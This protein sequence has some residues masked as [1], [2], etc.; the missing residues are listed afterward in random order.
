MFKLKRPL[1]ISIKLWLAMTLVILTV[2]GGLGL[3][4]T[5]LF[6]DFY[7]QQKL[8]ALRTEAT[9]IATE[10]A[11]LPDWP[12][13]LAAA[14]T[15][16]L[17]SG[18]QLVILDAGGNTLAVMGASFGNG[19]RGGFGFG[20]MGGPMSGW[21]RSPRPTD[22]FTAQNL[23]QVLSGDTLSIKAL[24]TNGNGQAMLIAAAPI[25]PNAVSGVVL[26]GSS[27]VPIQES[28]N[29]FRRLI[30]YASLL[31][32]I[33]A[34]LVS[35]ILARQMT[36]P[37]GLMQRAAKRMAEGNFDPIVGV[38][39][40]DE[41][42]EL[43]STLNS[44]GESLL[45]HVTWLSEEKNLLEGIVEGISDAVI[46]LGPNG[47][48]LYANDPAQALWTEDER[49]SEERK[50][51]I[52]AFLKELVAEKR[53]GYPLI[54]EQKSGAGVN[55]AGPDGSEAE[56]EILTLG[57]Q[58]LQIGVASLAENGGVRGNVLVLR[59][60]T[61]SLRAEKERRDFL[62]SVTHELRTPLHLI[63]GYL[64]AIQDG[65]IPPQEEGEH[66]NLV[67]DESKRLARLVQSLQEI[68]R[69]E[70][71]QALQWSDISLS[72][73]M[74]DLNQRFQGKA[75]D[76]GVRLLIRPGTG[77][78][79]ADRDRLLQV[80]INLI[81]NAL[82]HTPSGRTVVVEAENRKS[83]ILFMV[84]DEGEGIPP[85]A[86]R[87][88][89]ERFYRVDKSRSR[90]EGGMGLGLAI[91]KQ[92]VETHNGV[93]KVESELGQGTTFWVEIPNR[94]SD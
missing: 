14:Q 12:Q 32:I 22:F 71:S 58:I 60:V 73:F 15:S 47:E 37:L 93:I 50:K 43:A 2:L 84:R 44:M 49:E 4:I 59:D 36:R 42:G 40:R 62:A 55:E 63:Q 66:I 17:T 61:A 10:L 76:L 88:I 75:S 27:T 68:N 35:L 48:L 45:N 28:I 85:E 77:Q 23:L 67:L 80:F 16:K 82:R 79:E 46:M 21:G 92:I 65:V 5:W 8:D 69:L 31:A 20:G 81:D 74:Q 33:L 29:T 3:T 90:K 91:V 52:L 94:N 87:H 34:T 30:L 72:E 53:R 64:E 39:S 19:P 1:S 24:P 18:T 25:G 56:F 78:I 57:T 7:L 83:D 6:G 89:F 13:R 9:D 11:P 41:L 26:L 70:Q 51:E 86:L 54:A 38:T